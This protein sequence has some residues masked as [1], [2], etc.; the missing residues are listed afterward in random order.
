MVSGAAKDVERSRAAAVGA[1]GRAG[2]PA[3]P[4]EAAKHAAAP[5]PGTAYMEAYNKLAAAENRASGLTTQR[6][7][8]VTARDA[9]VIEKKAARDE[10][11]TLKNAGETGSKL[12]A[13]KERYNDAALK[14][15]QAEAGIRDIDQQLPIANQAC[16]AARVEMQ[17]AQKAYAA[18]GGK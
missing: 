1:K 14:G 4:A 7:E 15:R 13:A 12:E 11:E 17:K 8:L 2:A 9:S 5:K 3:L 18:A 16:S 6:Q 10:Y